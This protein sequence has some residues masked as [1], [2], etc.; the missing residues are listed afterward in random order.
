MRVG[1]VQTSLLAIACLRA[2]GGAGPQVLSHV[3]GLRKAERT[4]FQGLV[5]DA[6]WMAGDEGCMWVLR[7]VDRIVEAFRGRDA[8]Q[9]VAAKL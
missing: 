5:R 6:E 4:E 2:Q 1:R 8:G 7:V 9:D 3:Y